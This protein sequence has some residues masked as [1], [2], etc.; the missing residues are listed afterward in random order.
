M[1]RAG[2]AVEESEALRR[3]ETAFASSVR[4]DLPRNF[5]AHLAHGLLGQTGM[6][7]VN[8]PTFIPLYVFSLSGSEL[9]VGVARSLQYLGMF[10]S[11]I[12]G[13]T[14]IEHRPR[15]LRVGLLVGA[16]MRVQI[17]GLALGGILLSPPGPLVSCFVFLAL[18]GVFLGVQGVVFNFLVAKVIPVEVR[19][20]LVGLRNA[21][22]GLTAAAV[23]WY[24]GDV[25]I[26]GNALGNGYAATF[27]MAFALTSC[28]LL[29]L[30]FLR[31]PASPR[32]REA[33]AVRQRLGELPALLRSDPEFTRYFLARA[34]AVMGRMA[35]PFYAL[36]AQ[37]RLELSGAEWGQLTAIFVL[38]ES[39]GSLLWGAVADRTGFRRVFLA[40]LLI[41]ML[42]GV[43][44]LLTSSFAWLA[45]VFA[46]LGAGLGGFQMSAQNLVLEFGSRHNLPLRIAV[47]N[48]A[49]EF[50]AAV[51]AL[52]GGLLGMLVSHTAVFV[53]A[54]ASQAV[55]AGIVVFGVREPRSRPGAVTPR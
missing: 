29:M 31:E 20:R 13:A 26:E 6:R 30:L 28:G 7:L 55:A 14:I 5:L 3:A 35:V 42:S 22:S 53:V 33:A 4:A 27:L 2:G 41:W 19:G 10:A 49:S 39:V 32:V 1:P 12:V 21:L 37:A 43:A 24:A 36:H 9:A 47:A 17:L 18:F 44:L 51:G 48:S 16:L 11:P 50:V 46:G 45:I 34:L 23:A 54:I 52:L 38:M 25:L 8:A 40:A 15:V